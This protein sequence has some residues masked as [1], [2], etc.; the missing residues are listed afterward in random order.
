M[1]SPTGR[2]GSLH[3]LE[4]V[5]IKPAGNVLADPC[6]LDIGLPEVETLPHARVDGVVDQVGE[7]CV[8]RASPGHAGDG[9]DDAEVHLVRAEE[10][11]GGVH[12]RGR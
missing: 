2:I 9:P 1:S 10:R 5:L 7:A 8:V 6:A 3:W 11:P 12:V 4:E